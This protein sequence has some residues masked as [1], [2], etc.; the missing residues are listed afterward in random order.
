[1]AAK[2]KFLNA[3]KMPSMVCQGYKQQNPFCF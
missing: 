2:N 3:M 1:M